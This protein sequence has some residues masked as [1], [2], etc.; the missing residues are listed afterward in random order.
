MNLNAA[1][2]NPL[3]ILCLSTLLG[4]NPQQEQIKYDEVASADSDNQST[5]VNS[6]HLCDDLVNSVGA[7]AALQ[8]CLD[9]AK[10]N[11]K[12]A[13]MRVGMLH[14]LGELGEE[15]WE[16]GMHWLLLAAQ[17]GHTEAQYEVAQSYL[18]GR[19][20][21]QNLTEAFQWL[22]QAAKAN[23]VQAQ[24]L[25]GLCYL[26]GQGT[27]QNVQQALEW[28]SLSAKQNDP[29]AEYYLGLMYL[30]GNGIAQ[31]SYLGEKFLQ[32]AAEQ[33]LVVAQLAL[34]KLY[35]S[36]GQLA[37]NDSQSY[38][39]YNKAAAE[40]DPQGLYVVGMSH[41]LG[42][43]GQKK[44]LDAAGKYLKQAADKNYYPAQYALATLYLE[45]Q[46]VLQ[47][48]HAAIEF[49]RLAANGGSTDAQI[50]LAKILVEFSLPQ[51]D[52]VA[53]YWADKAA[54]GNNPEAKYLLGS[55][56]L[57][58]IGT[59][60][61]YEKA[62]HIF[63]DLADQ[64]NALAEFKL[65]QMYYYGQGVEKN[66]PIAK[67][68][69]LKSARLGVKDAKNWVAILFRDGMENRENQAD[70]LDQEDLNQWINYSADN[71]E[72]EGLYL[73][74]MGFLYG[75]NNFQQ[76]IEE[77]LQFITQAA[78]MQF[79]PAQRELG[80]LYEE[81]LF[82]L[83]DNAKAYDWYLKASQNG[84]GYSQYRLATM[85]YVGTGVQRDYV[86]SYAWAHLAAVGG[87]DD[88]V[89]LREEISNLLDARQLRMA[90]QLST[91]YFNA[92]K[93]GLQSFAMP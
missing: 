71:G 74:G 45:G 60:V 31:N 14:A 57:D 70:D 17:N 42:S 15:N 75:R 8:I 1:L 55:Y 19:G 73:K 33:S 32:A 44:D 88:A 66:L 56:Y 36:G 5:P 4:C 6:P 18:L 24:A 11:N 76:S 41:A 30:E 58:G 89:A 79:V 65:G 9:Q 43:F 26:K 64:G 78:Q 27:K 80:K 68:W 46:P 21:S 10:S 34:A 37:Q 69:F 29:V 82:G 12:D 48:K 28:F 47:D 20:V 63:S 52:K 72:P 23:H 53:F 13:Q 90:Q 38:F 54:T 86:Q 3:V 92:H 83:N 84:D 25:L 50:K 39:W 93:K 59:Q 61:D 87:K 91:E 51:Y 35:Q 85:F 22:Q 49:L 40:G 67:K 2:R 77:G 81:G 62:F 16:Q 7:R